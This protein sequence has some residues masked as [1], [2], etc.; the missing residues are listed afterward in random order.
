MNARYS[1][2]ILEFSRTV[3]ALSLWPDPF[4]S[5]SRR[6]MYPRYGV[7]VSAII[8]EII[9]AMDAPMGIGLIY[10]PISPDTK[11]IGRTA[12]ITV[13]VANIVGLPTSFIANIAACKGGS[14]FILKCRCMFSAI[15]ME[16]STTIPVIKTSAKRVILFNV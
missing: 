4:F 13:N 15:M 9:I 1:L 5:F 12:A 10:G 8:R 7:N 6:K 3:G 14:L 16:S 2:Y 11:A